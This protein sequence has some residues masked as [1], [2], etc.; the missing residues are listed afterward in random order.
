MSMLTCCRSFGCFA[1]VLVFLAVLT[2]CGITET[3]KAQAGLPLSLMLLPSVQPTVTAGLERTIQPPVQQTVQLPARLTVQPSVPPTPTLFIRGPQFNTALDLW[4]G[5]VDLPL[6]LQIP[7]LHVTAPVLGVG[8]IAGNVMDAPKG[9]IGDPAWHT[10]FWYRGSSIPGEP[11]TATIAGHVDNLLGDPE[12]FAHLQRL[13]PGDLIIVHVKNTTIDIRFIVDQVKVYSTAES[14]DPAVLNQIF[15][16]GPA[17]GSG[18]QPPPDGLSHLTLIT[19]AGYIFNGLFDH[20]T[21]VY[22]TLSK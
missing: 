21:I 7:S 18:S 8:L 1:T 11:G 6:E 13:H 10:A 3:G 17:A 14:S 4:A 16:G 5:P 19:C 20:H 12:I 15:G 2:G 9:P 22:T